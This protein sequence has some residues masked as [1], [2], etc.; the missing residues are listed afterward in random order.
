MGQL[1]DSLVLPLPLVI[2]YV[3]V[4]LTFDLHWKCS[5][6]VHKQ[7][8]TYTHTHTHTHTLCVQEHTDIKLE[9]AF[10][11][12]DIEKLQSFA[13]KHTSEEQHIDIPVGRR[14]AC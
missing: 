14:L 1:S 11:T 2:R 7:V 10:S 13:A 9:D 4:Q 5:L 6:N 8:D 3:Y 12:G